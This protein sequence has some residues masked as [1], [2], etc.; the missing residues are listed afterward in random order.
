MVDT[1]SLFFD[2]SRSTGRSPMPTAT[3]YN[4]SALATE[5]LSTLR[6]FVDVTF[7]DYRPRPKI[8]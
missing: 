2:A 3:L 6:R 8:F 5:E 7:T 1:Q 4:L